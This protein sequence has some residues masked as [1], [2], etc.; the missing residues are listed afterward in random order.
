MRD[1]M[2]TEDSLE[3]DY[4]VAIVGYGP[5]GLA[6]AYWLGQAGHRTVVIE[7]WPELYKL[8]RAAHVDGEVMRLF[9]RMGIAETIASDS[10][11]IGHTVVRDSQGLQLTKVQAEDSDQGWASHY[12]LFQPNLEIALDRQVRS[13]GN[14]TVLQGWQA[15]RIERSGSYSV[16]IEIA[17]GIGNGGHWVATGQRQ[18]ISARWLIGA[19]G[20]NSLVQNF[21]GSAVEDLGYSDRA[22]V[23][24]ARR[25]DPTV[26]S[27][28]PDSE[29]GMVLPRPYAAWRESGKRFARFEFLV[30]GHETTPEMSTEAKTWELIAPWGFTPA[31][32]ELIR[33]TVYEYR[34]LVVESWRNNNILLAGDAA[35]RMPPFQGQGMC[36]GLRDA[37]ALAWR[38]DLVLRGL[39]DAAILDSYTQERRPHVRQLTLNAAERGK[40]FWLTD[41]EAARRRDAFLREMAVNENLK[42]GY[43][44]MPPLSDGLLMKGPDGLVAPAGRLSAQFTV[45]H[46]SQKFLLDDHIG[47]RWLLLSTDPLLVQALNAAESLLLQRLSAHT[48]VLSGNDTQGGFHDVNGEY[49]RWMDELGCR[50]VLIRPDCYIFGGANNRQGIRAMLESLR[51]QLHLT[52]DLVHELELV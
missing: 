10:S 41:P 47:A 44:S 26:G 15:E 9:Q 30:H 1:T 43:G 6:L 8:P 19:D 22:L 17:A 3:N 18:L 36:S 48:I 31:N 20:A 37:V 2:D 16:K 12:S 24:F 49:R 7:R 39:A 42:R 29:V 50:L 23:I 38:L 40:Q 33:H 52:A 51:E 45:M 46:D 13:S 14:V 27:T 25:L 34:T 21:L 28:M 11:I 32:A 5:T 4:D 35:H